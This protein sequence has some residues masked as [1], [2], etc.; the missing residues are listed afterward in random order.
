LS[1]QL[2]RYLIAGASTVTLYVGGVWFF[3][4][5]INWPARPVNA[6]LYVTATGL[7][8]LFN[9]IWVF[10]SKAKASGAL[11]GFLILQGFG[12][13]LN[14]AWLEAGLRFTVIYPWIIAATFFAAWPFLSFIIQRRFI[15]NR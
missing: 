7:S 2:S 14:L 9:Y 11:L 8:F 4:E 3:T 6:V 10:A 13:L 12:V 5:I 15:F 1:S